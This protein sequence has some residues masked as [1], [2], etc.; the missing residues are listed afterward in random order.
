MSF[1][2][3][4]TGN[5]P[6]QKPVIKK[7]DYTYLQAHSKSILLGILIVALLGTWS[8]LIWSKTKSNEQKQ[9]L[10]T[11]LSASDS[12]K[13]NLQRDLNEAVMSLDALKSTNAAAE[14]LLRTKDKSI[15]DLTQRIQKIIYDKNANSTQ[16]AQARGLI[17]QLKS[18]IDTYAAEIAKLKNENIQITEEKKVITVERDIV[19]RNFDSAKTVIK[20]KEDVIDIGST[21]HASN[22]NVS[23]VK[24]RSGGKEKE[25]TTAKRVD[26]LKIS[27][28]LDENR[29]A[30][31]GVKQIYINIIAP[32]GSAIVIPEAGVAKFTTRD[33]AEKSATKK[34]DVEYKQGERKQVSFELAKAQNFTPGDYKIEIYN[35]GFKIGEGVRSFKKGGLFS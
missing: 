8:Y 23:G 26:K 31:S 9:Q 33:G 10:T 34:V 6:E 13:N 25:T 30:Q 22:L 2:N 35:N 14:S 18:N 11:Q 28:D 29:I 16:L 27:F 5:L 15:Q 32:D 19:R 20:Q 17:K 24:Q 7:Y 21:L 12:S 4:P 3:F 1:E